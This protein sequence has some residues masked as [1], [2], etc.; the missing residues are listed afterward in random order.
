MTGFFGSLDFF[1]CKL[2]RNEKGG[3]FLSLEKYGN[4]NSGSLGH[5]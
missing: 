2:E 5:G 4:D 3:R 1:I